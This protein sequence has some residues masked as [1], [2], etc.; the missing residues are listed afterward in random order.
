MIFH[1][2]DRV[3]NIALV[4]LK[5]GVDREKAAQELVRLGENVGDPFSA[6]KI[7]RSLPKSIKVKD[8]NLEAFKEVF[9][10]Q[11]YFHH[12]RILVGNNLPTEGRQVWVTLRDPDTSPEM[13]FALLTG[14]IN[15]PPWDKVLRE[16]HIILK[17]GVVLTLDKEPL[18]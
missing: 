7:L 5:P 12:E 18:K 4:D 14:L 17:N 16:S 8:D 15:Q 2:E 11:E 9:E 3:W 10:T 6:H 13:Y 1:T